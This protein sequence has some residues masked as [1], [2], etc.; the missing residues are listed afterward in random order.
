MSNAAQ[1]HTAKV[2]WIAASAQWWV[3]PVQGTDSVVSG[4]SQDVRPFV[5]WATGLE[6]LSS[7]QL[8]LSSANYSVHWVDMPGVSNRHLARALPFALEETLIGDLDELFI[9]PDGKETGLVKAYVVAEPLLEQLLALCETYHLQVK[10]LIPET[11]LLPAHS[12][13]ATQEKYPA[14]QGDELI[15]GWLVKIP[16]RLEGWINDSALNSLLDASLNEYQSS[17]SLQIGCQTVD[18]GSLVRTNLLVGQPDAYAEIDLQVGMGFQSLAGKWPAK[19]LSFLTGAFKPKDVRP[20]RPAAWWRPLAGMAAVWLLMVGGWLMVENQQLEQKSQSIQKESRALY[21]QLFPGERIRSMER[22]FRSK[23]EDAGGGASAEGFV[24]LV[25]TTAKA[26]AEAS[27][28]KLSITSMR[29]NERQQELLLEVT[30]ATLA[31]LQSLQK[32]IEGQGL[33]AEV[34]SANNEKEGVKGR[35]KVKGAA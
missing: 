8:I 17:S 7:V 4:S 5:D 1:I 6:D 20:N 2:T 23:L 32:A 22:S 35:L 21:K 34:A 30:A 27:V 15:K 19:P 25:N 10:E 13:V 31:D 14:E 3:L 9:L 11:L 12:V 29:F 33:E 24:G 18:Q 26:Y 16:G 28:N